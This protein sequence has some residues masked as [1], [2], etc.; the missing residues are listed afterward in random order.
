MKLIT[1]IAMLLL[2]FSA[3]GKGDGNAF[4][5]N[6]GKDGNTEDSATGFCQQDETWICPELCDRMSCGGMDPDCIR[7]CSTELQDCTS[8]DLAA[9]CSC[10]ETYLTDVVCQTWEEAQPMWDACIS[11]IACFDDY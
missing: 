11:E 10:F 4:G 2:A 7:I 9:T 1:S 8:S 3:C 5:T 6:S